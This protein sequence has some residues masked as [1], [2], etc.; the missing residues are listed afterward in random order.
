MLEGLFSKIS[1][2]VSLCIVK[3]VLI[4]ISYLAVN[5]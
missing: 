4:G 3:L 5:S 2:I 1:E